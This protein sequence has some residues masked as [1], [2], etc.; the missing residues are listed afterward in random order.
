M[1]DLFG[2]FD[3]INKLKEAMV[4]VKQTLEV[5]ELKTTSANAEVQVVITASK[6]IKTI[7][8]DPT[9]VNA[10]NLNELVADTVN[11]ALKLA[12]KTA[13][14]ATKK[15]TEGKIP[16]IPGLDLSSLGL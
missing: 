14:E 5:T 6:K 9:F 4:E 16:N 3:K 2:M 1:F 12:S 10:P 15:A 7:T 13:K 11:E 8:I